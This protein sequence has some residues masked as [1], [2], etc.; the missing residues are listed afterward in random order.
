MAEDSLILFVLAFAMGVPAKEGARVNFARS[1]V[2]Q[3]ALVWRQISQINHIIQAQTAQQ[4]AAF[5]LN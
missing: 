4:N 2:S 1:S 5:N 3:R